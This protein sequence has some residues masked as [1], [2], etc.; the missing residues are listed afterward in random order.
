MVFRIEIADD[1]VA[2]IEQYLDGQRRPE[3]DALTGAVV[4]KRQFDSVAAFISFQIG[5]LLES[6]VQQ[7][8]TPTQRKILEEIAERRRAIADS[9]KPQAS[10]TTGDTGKP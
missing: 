6:I 5:N 10:A 8:P 7:Y 4:V 2:C 9:V 1:L 3:T